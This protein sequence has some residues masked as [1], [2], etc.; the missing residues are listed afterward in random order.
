MHR[1]I[2]NQKLRA[3]F[4]AGALVALLLFFSDTK[5]GYMVRDTALN[6]ISPVV[7]AAANIRAFMYGNA[8][9]GNSIE[10]S[11]FSESTEYMAMTFRIESLAREN[12]LLRIMLAFRERSGREWRGFE[13]RAYSRE[14]GKETLVIAAGFR[15]GVREGDLVVDEYGLL[16]GVVREVTD[17]YAKVSLASNVG[18]TFDVELVPG[19]VRALAKGIGARAFTIQLVP[20]DAP[21]RR[22]DYVAVSSP[23]LPRNALLAEIA[24]IGGGMSVAFH[25]IKAV[26]LARPERSRM[27]LVIPQE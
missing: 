15:D 17:A 4:A 1:L 12:E 6:G 3:T 8:G 19:N 7:R 23:S 21:I 2:A 14:F 16:V 10:D 11:L 27:V 24:D 5:M 13:V 22:G 26:L 25:E 20:T 18:E 9:N